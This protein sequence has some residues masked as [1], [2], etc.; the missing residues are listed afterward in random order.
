MGWL[1]ITFYMLSKL[2]I[3]ASYGAIYIFTTEQFP[4]VVRNIG[5]GVSS[6]CAKLGGVCAPQINLLVSFSRYSLK[7][8]LC[9]FH[10]ILFFYIL[11]L[12]LILMQFFNYFYFLYCFQYFSFPL[13]L[14]KI[15]SKIF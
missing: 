3:T 9:N 15:F 11:Y 1:A 2:A 6:T 8:Y 14:F 5:L 4:T 13:F 10:L 12:F 7:I